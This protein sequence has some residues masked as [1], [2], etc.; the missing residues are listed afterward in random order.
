VAATAVPV[1]N[2]RRSTFGPEFLPTIIG[3]PDSW[4]WS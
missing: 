1:K 4:R 2:L 3:F